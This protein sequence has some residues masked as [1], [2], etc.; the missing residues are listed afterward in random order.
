[1]DA[2]TD[3]VKVTAMLLILL[4]GA[5]IFSRFLSFSRLPTELLALAAPLVEQPNLLVVVLMVGIFAAGMFLEEVTVIVLAV[6][7]ILPM[8]EAAQIDLIWF[9][10]M[11]CFMIS[12]GLLT[13]PVGLVAF[14]A[15]S[16]ARVPVG[17]V[18]KP[19][20]VFSTAAAIV[21]TLAMMIFPGLATWLPSHLN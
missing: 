7:I 4:I 19:A 2:L 14:S 9:G 8:V 16:A 11:A 13:P 18:F 12:L 3:S 1:M 10:V 17:P 15:A 21:V 5:Q 20:M 6:P